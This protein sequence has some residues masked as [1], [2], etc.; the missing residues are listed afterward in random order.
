[1]IFKD[2]RCVSRK[3]GKECWFPEHIAQDREFM[4]RHDFEIDDPAFI[5]ELDNRRRAS[6]P[7]EVEDANVKLKE[8]IIEQPKRGRKPNK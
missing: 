1:M 7:K 8:E 6:I 2:I 5:L 4:N 3:T